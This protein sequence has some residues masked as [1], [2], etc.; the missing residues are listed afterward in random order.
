MV[1]RPPAV[2]RRMDERRRQ[3]MRRV[4]HAKLQVHTGTLRGGIHGAK[5]IRP[6]GQVLRGLP[7]NKNNLSEKTNQAPEYLLEKITSKPVRTGL[8]TIRNH[9]LLV[10]LRGRAA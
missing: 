5:P 7:V 2:R 3:R 6:D 10:S 1:P 4:H 9:R 8:Q